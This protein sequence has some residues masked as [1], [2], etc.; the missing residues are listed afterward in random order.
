MNKIYLNFPKDIVYVIVNNEITIYQFGKDYK[1]KK[2]SYYLV[3]DLNRLEKAENDFKDEVEEVLE[4]YQ[5]FENAHDSWSKSYYNYLGGI[6]K[7]AKKISIEKS[8]DIKLFKKNC[9]GSLEK[10]QVLE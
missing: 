8:I 6:Y 3:N 10:F 2:F 4:D 1:Y 5:T 9:E 7:Y